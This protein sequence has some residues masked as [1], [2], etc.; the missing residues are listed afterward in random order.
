MKL[1][2]KLGV[3]SLAL[4]LSMAV[5]GADVAAKAHQYGQKKESSTDSQN[6]TVRIPREQFVADATVDSPQKKPD[7]G[8]GAK[9]AKITGIGGVFFKSKNPAE[10]TQWYQTNL[11]L[12]LEDWGGAILRWKDDKAED[13]GAT[14]WHVKENEATMFS[15]SS[16]SFMINYRIDSMD[17]M[18]AQLKRNGVEIQK[19]PESH[20]NGKFLWVMDPDGNKVE[21][22]EPKIW[23]EK[24]KQ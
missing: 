1:A 9:M 22:W 24:N 10:L 13:N 8:Q 11:G 2:R 16:S 14:V 23:N 19:G 15:P 5:G 18:V 7:T 20:E 12:K 6:D 21:L 17:D 4:A 3:A